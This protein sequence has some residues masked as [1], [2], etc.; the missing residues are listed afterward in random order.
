MKATTQEQ[1]I[2]LPMDQITVEGQVRTEFDEES[3]EG[4]AASIQ[5]VGQLVPVRVR[6][7]GDSFILVD[8]ER[9]Y[10]AMK[11]LGSKTIAAIVEN[12]ELSAGDIVQRQLIANVQRDDLGGIEKARAIH[13]LM[14]T[15]DWNAS[16]AAA[17]LGMSNATVSRLL[18]L[19]ALPDDIQQKIAAG[20]IP[21]SVA[22]Q[23]SQIEDGA[24]QAEVADAVV[25]GRMTRDA[26]ASRRRRRK[27]KQKN[28]PASPKRVTVIL[29]LG[30]SVTVT[31]SDLSLESFINVISEVL[32]KARKG[33]ASG[34]QLSSFIAML[35]DQAQSA[36]AE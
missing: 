24:E 35:R 11:L 28:S 29:G 7:E 22:Y 23:L 25:Q 8:G 4:L 2:Y 14:E 30:R 18:S 15:T 26:I 19:L 12:A 1:I 3:L 13:H 20:E 6:Q 9:R 34:I 32:E 16:E 33:R 5:A 31:G 17:Q 36:V 27:T 21:A 10:R